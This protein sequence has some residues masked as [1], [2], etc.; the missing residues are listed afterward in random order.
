MTEFADVPGVSLAYD[1]TGRG[2]PPMVLVHGWGGDRSY[3][4]PQ[5]EFFARGHAV[6]ALDLR[7][8]GESGQPT[9]GSGRYSVDV[10]ADDVLAVAAAAGL[11]RPVLVGHSL[12]A[13]I[14]LSGAARPG[15]LS[16]LVMVDPAPITNE[17]AKAYFRD[18]AARSARTRTGR[19]A[20]SSPRGCSCP[21]TRYAGTRSSPG[22][23]PGRRGSRLTSSRP[24]GS[25]TG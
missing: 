8:H 24:W 20:P 5:S 16:A 9:P 23:R 25:S 2:E 6:L 17:R 7:G 11:D 4:A 1:V 14:G 22:S 3:L 12:G 13:L 19:G 18:S 15:A 10:L 21:P